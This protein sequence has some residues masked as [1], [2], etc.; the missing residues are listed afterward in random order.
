MNDYKFLINVRDLLR[1]ADP[2]EYS[3]ESIEDYEE[4]K[5]LVEKYCENWEVNH[6]NKNEGLDDSTIEGDYVSCWITQYSGEPLFNCPVM[7]ELRKLQ[8]HRD[9]KTVDHFSIFPRKLLS[10]HRKTKE[11]NNE[12][13]QI[14]K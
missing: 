1:K 11:E 5:D 6:R 4:L 13:K 12:N 3:R 10:N 2:S 9:R 14:D 8:F 7:S